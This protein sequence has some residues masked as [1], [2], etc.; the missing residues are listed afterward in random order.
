M[1]RIQ[2]FFESVLNQILS[3]IR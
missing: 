3:D 1:Y 2:F